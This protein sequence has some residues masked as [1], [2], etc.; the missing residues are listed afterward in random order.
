MLD[1][2]PPETIQYGSGW[3]PEPILY[4]LAKRKVPAPA[5]NRTLQAVTL[6]TGI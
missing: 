6:H 3:V 1:K 4:P 5:G 2:E